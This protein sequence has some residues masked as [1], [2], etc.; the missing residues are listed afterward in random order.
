V[1]GFIWSGIKFA[2]S[3]TIALGAGILVASVAFALLTATVD[4]GVARIKGA[5]SRNWRGAYDLLVLPAH[6]A[7]QAASGKAGRTRLVQDNYLSAATGGITMGQYGKIAH[8]PGVGVAAPLA[9]VGYVLETADVPVDVSAAAGR[10]GARVLAVTSRFTADQGLSKYPPQHD[11]YA[12][13]TPDS[14]SPYRFNRK[15]GGVER[16]EQL[17]DGRSVGV[18][19]I[20][21]RPDAALQSSPFQVAADA[22]L[23]SCYSRASQASGPVN[24]VVEWSFPVLVAGINPQA[25]NR[26]TGLAR[27]VTS[28]RYL[29]QSQG[30]IRGG[31]GGNGTVVPV[32]GSTVSFDGDVD[33]VSVSLL[34]APA[35]AA[36]R[37]GQP[38]ARIARV[39]DSEKAA[40]ITPVTI[41]GAE[42]WQ[43]LLSQLAAPITA[44]NSQYAQAIG[45][46]WTVGA[47][48]YQRGADGRLVPA[49]TANPDSVWL[50]G[51]N[52][53]GLTYVAAPPGAADTGFR[54]LTEHRAVLGA[55]P[56][57]LKLVGEFDPYSLPGFA[58]TGPGSPLASYRAPLETG[59][60]AASRSLLGGRPLLP[61]GNMAGYAQQPPLLYTTLAGAAALE[62]PG[63][64]AGTGEQAAAPIGSI[65]VRVSGLRGSVPQK[66]AKIAAVGQEIRTT[67]GLRVDVTAGSS[68]QAVTID[69]AAGRFGRPALLLS[70]PW[71]ATGVALVIL[72]QADRES[73][74][75]FILILVVCALFLASAALAGVRG[76]RHEIGALQALGWSRR[77]VFTLVLGEVVALGL[78]AGLAGAVLSAA[79]IAGLGLDVPLWRAVL[80]L[81]AAVVLS[82]GAGLGP[83]WLAA[84]T[85]LLAALAGP[86][87]APHHGGRRF[88]T[89]TG[90]A[91]TGVARVPGRCALAGAALAIGVAGLAVLLAAQAS[92]GTS[93]GDSA[94]AGLVTANTRGSDLASALLAIGLGAAAV[95]DMT[96]LNLRERS[97][98]LAALAACGWGRAQLGRLLGTEG[99]ITAVTGAVIGAAAG[100]AAAAVAFGISAPVIAG[101]VIAAAGGTIVALIGTVA[102]LASSSDRPLA[103]VLAADE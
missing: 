99:L 102:V 80:V 51:T 18:C 49:P 42:A 81:P 19:A 91:L 56:A 63:V 3:R 46:Y 98:E 74:A 70:E 82:L 17:P 20:D 55:A 52:T 96:Y 83:A 24:A 22:G 40:P 7:G 60:T 57:F 66:L 64:Y 67:T 79:L 87:R 54:P 34:P 93:I 47:V 89:V 58:G 101:A 37:S 86:A 11:G 88:R 1:I 92:L 44:T 95:A 25:D 21:A 78:L 90:L 84:R 94:L 30:T 4:V 75:L 35:V 33:R 5:V 15:G 76:R 38:P 71:T 9:I 69:L 77:S 16:L 13:I 10:S 8:L 2:R 61:D 65:R 45:Q 27:A 100:L 29:S 48:K 28:G 23:N 26:L 97:A 85:G 36:V 39:L 12:Y 14:L 41:T 72:H 68:S 31:S 53:N 43:Q 32:L 73:L 59:A 6:S 103:A 50:A 62:N